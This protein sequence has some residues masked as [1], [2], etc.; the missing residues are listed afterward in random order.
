MEQK[1]KFK[2]LRFLINYDQESLRSYVF[3]TIKYGSLKNIKWLY[4]HFIFIHMNKDNINSD[5]YNDLLD[6]EEDIKRILNI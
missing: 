3:N 2:N 4:I 5:I 6:M 1:N